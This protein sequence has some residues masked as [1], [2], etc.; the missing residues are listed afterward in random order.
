[1]G[2]ASHIAYFKCLSAGTST[3]SQSQAHP[4][5]LPCEKV[6][7]YT[8]LHYSANTEKTLDILTLLFKPYII[9]L[10]ILITSQLLRKCLF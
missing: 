6:Y 2:L 8:I 9:F 4:K 1:M 7:P 3:R 10:G 5:F